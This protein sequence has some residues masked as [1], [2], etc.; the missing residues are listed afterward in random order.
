MQSLIRATLCG[1]SLEPCILAAPPN[2]TR[3]AAV[4]LHIRKGCELLAA[5]TA[6]THPFEFN[7]FP[8]VRVAVSSSSLG[9][10]KGN[11]AAREAT[12][13]RHLASAPL[14]PA[15]VSARKIIFLLV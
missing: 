7:L 12:I 13:W 8:K 6:A 5:Q 4:A 9:A 14:K 10:N 1:L 3:K 11:R 2:D 15:S